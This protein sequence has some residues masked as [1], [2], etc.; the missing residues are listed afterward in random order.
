MES[1]SYITFGC[2]IGGP[3][4][5]EVMQPHL[6][7]LSL[8]LDKYCDYPYSNDVDEFAPIGRIDGNIYY[9]KF[10]GCEKL[11]LSKKY[12]YITVDIGMP[13]SRWEEKSDYEIREYLINCFQEA[14]SLIVKR[15]KKEKFSIDD[16]KLFTDFE[17]VKV[18]Y[19]Q[20]N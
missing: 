12:R 10:E 1:S 14:L 15:L 16:K 3:K 13:K 4:A 11:R 7:K 8:L 2:Q 6:I 20:I 19:L 17:K 18:D 5:G 9:W